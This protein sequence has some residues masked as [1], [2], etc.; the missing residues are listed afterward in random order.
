MIS[1]K[2]ILESWQITVDDTLFNSKEEEVP[3]VVLMKEA[4]VEAIKEIVSRKWKYNGIRSKYK[5]IDEIALELI[6]EIES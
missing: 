1:N 3:V 6:K 2:Q 4:Q 5:P